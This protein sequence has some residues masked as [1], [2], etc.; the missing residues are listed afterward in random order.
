MTALFVTF[1][2]G[3]G[4]GKTTQLRM[5]AERLQRD[6]VPTTVTREPGGTDVGLAL[7]EIVLHHKGPIDPKAEALIYAADRA[8]H[9]AQVVR[10]ALDRGDVVVQDRYIDST[11]AYQ[12]AGRALDPHTLLG[13]SRWA[14]EDTWPDLTVLLDIDPAAAIARSSRLAS[15]PDRIEAAGNDFRVKLRAAFLE[16]A[17]QEP[18]RFLIIDATLPRGVQHNRV[19]AAVRQRLYAASA[20]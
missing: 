2:G 3:D 12:G 13:I 4:A 19:L 16:L 10:P 11:L 5:L 14:A 18:Q 1:E 15:D 9:I 6:G 8:Q 17:K 20:A 7:R